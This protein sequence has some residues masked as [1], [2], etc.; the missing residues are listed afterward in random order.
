MPDKSLSIVGFEASLSKAR[1]VRVGNWRTGVCVFAHGKS[2]IKM[3]AEATLSNNPKLAGIV[4]AL[5]WFF[6]SYKLWAC[7]GM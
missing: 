5:G 7:G 6:S 4:T 1:S 3:G 2:T